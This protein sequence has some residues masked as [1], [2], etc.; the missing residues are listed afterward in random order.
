MKKTPDTLN[1]EIVSTVIWKCADIHT[2]PK[3]GNNMHSLET[4]LAH[5]VQM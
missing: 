1:L 3:L 4:A 2:N 5:I